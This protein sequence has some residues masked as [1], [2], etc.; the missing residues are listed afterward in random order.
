MTVSED[1]SQ[2]RLDAS[3]NALPELVRELDAPDPTS[4]DVPAAFARLK[5]LVP[6]ARIAGTDM[7]PLG[8]SLAALKQ[9]ANGEKET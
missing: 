3:L 5:E 1:S 6:D 9:P 2:S 4:A 8:S 7:K